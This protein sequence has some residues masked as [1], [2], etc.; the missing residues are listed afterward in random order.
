MEVG[1]GIGQPRA[2]MQ[3]GH[4]R[5]ARHPAEA[6]RRSG[7]DPFEQAQNSPHPL[8]RGYQRGGEMEL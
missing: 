8:F 5:P 4:G 3:Q 2:L 6:I 7:G 1:Q